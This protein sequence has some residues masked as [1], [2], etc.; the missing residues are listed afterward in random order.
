MPKGSSRG[1][2][3]LGR[4][5][6]RGY[7]AYDRIA[8]PETDDPANHWVRIVL[9]DAID[10]HIRKLDPTASRAAEVSGDNHR[11]RPWLSYE[12]LNYPDFDLCAPLELTKRFDVVICEQVLEHVPDPWTAAANLR[13]LIRP[14]GHVIVSTPF[15]IRV[16]ELPLFGMHDYWRFSP[17]GIRILLEGAGLV[18]DSVGSWGNRPAVAGNLSRWA[19]YR[20]W[21]SLRNEPDVPVQIWAFAHRAS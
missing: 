14:G 11:T 4:L 12:T 1:R 21:H 20:R 17:R 7:D 3:L 13:E 19:A 15:L 8:Y 2:R 10:A 9:N 16:H 6:W 5:A 18:I